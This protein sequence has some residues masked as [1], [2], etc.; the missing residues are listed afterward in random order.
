M[1][2]MVVLHNIL[3]LEG[4]ATAAQFLREGQTVLSKLKGMKVNYMWDNVVK[5]K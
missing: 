2:I 5:P 3:L 4:V 1:V